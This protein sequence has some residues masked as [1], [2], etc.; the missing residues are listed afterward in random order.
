[1]YRKLYNCCI[2]EIYSHIAIT[3]SFCK[4]YTSEIQQKYHVVGRSRQLK[5]YFTMI[6]LGIYNHCVFKYNDFT[7][8]NAPLPKYNHCIGTIL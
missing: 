7:I 1:M 2:V 6:V 5:P 8:S 3:T 4:D